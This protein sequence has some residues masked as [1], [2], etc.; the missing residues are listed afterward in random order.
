MSSSHFT[1]YFTLIYASRKKQ[2]SNRFT[3]MCGHK[4]L[5]IFEKQEARW[6]QA[7][8]LCLL[9]SFQYCS[10]CGC[11]ENVKVSVVNFIFR[12]PVLLFCSNF[13]NAQ[14][15][16]YWPFKSC[17]FTIFLMYRPRFNSRNS[18]TKKRFKRYFFI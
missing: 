13:V 1:N 6:V 8:Y 15:W 11:F 14:I 7:G 4:C 16:L 3:E 2:T 17:I 9:K 5:T 18:N 12:K 10:V